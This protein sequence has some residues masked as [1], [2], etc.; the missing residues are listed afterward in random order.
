MNLTIWIPLTF[1]LG[2]VSMLVFY[3][4]LKA[5]EKI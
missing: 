1:G 4:F 3:A 5:C 2:I